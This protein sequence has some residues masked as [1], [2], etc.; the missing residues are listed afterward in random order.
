VGVGNVGTD[1]G[2]V[3]LIGDTD[4]DPLFLRVKEAQASVLEPFAGPGAYGKHGQRVAE[5]QT[6]TPAPEA[7]CVARTRS[8]R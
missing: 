8:L 2:V 5:G 6:S 1:D 4:S 7:P 3:L